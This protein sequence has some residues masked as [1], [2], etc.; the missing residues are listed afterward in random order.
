MARNFLIP[1][2][3]STVIH[4]GV[5]FLTTLLWGQVVRDRTLLDTKY[6]RENGG[7]NADI[8]LGRIEE[9]VMTAVIA[10]LLASFIATV[11]WFLRCLLYKDGGAMGPA[12]Q[13]GY[14]LVLLILG[15]LAANIYV[16]FTVYSDNI[17]T[18]MTQSAF[19]THVAVFEISYLLIFLVA[20][21]ISTPS[22]MRPAVPFASW[23]PG[24]LP[25]S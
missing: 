13:R 12:R 11:L 22:W 9:A 5:F 14:W 1:T 7:R 6:L 19:V 23:L 4:A 24:G 2:V 25:F 16:I 3:V 21:I 17:P 10:M 15:F 8:Y 18:I 20:S